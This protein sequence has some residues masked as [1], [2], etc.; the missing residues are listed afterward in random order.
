M[1]FCNASLS[2]VQAEHIVEKLMPAAGIAPDGVTYNTLMVLYGNSGDMD[3]AYRSAFAPASRFIS[4]LRRH[5]LQDVTS[6]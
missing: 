3:G 6:I 1:G 5:P 2:A 4:G